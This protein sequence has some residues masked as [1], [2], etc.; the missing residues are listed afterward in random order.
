[1]EISYF[2][3][4]LLAIVYLSVGIGALSKSFNYIKIYDDFV[5]SPGLTYVTGFFVILLGYLVVYYHN[6]WV[7]KWYVIIT[8]FGWL[9]LVKGIMLVAFPGWLK[10]FRPLVKGSF[11]NS[12]GYL[13]LILGLIFAYF[14]F[15]AKGGCMGW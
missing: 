11:G 15:F 3:A 8:I 10:S 13:G 2:V 9:A 1:M 14:G 12:V 7:A 5:K 6:I 4:Q